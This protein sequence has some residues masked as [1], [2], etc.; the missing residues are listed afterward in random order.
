MG[1]T[2]CSYL[3]L[4][5]PVEREDFFIKVGEEW[6]CPGGHVRDENLKQKF[7]PD[8]GE[9]FEFHDVEEPT[10][11]FAAYVKETKPDYTPED[12]YCDLMGDSLNTGQ[13][14]IADGAAR[15]GDS[16]DEEMVVAYCLS[17]IEE[18]NDRRE[19]TPIPLFT[20]EDAEEEVLAL[21][22][23]LGLNATAGDLRL[24]HCL[25]IS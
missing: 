25:Y 23:R 15:Q 9:R 7:C 4:G 22:R 2:I 11:A 19:H 1:M 20:L 16:S 12:F 10:E 3:L 5:F 17:D 14:G 8:C 21:G 13:V 6:R 24:F 18:W